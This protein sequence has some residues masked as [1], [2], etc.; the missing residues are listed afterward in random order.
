MSSQPIPKNYGMNSS[1]I[2]P[3]NDD[4]ATPERP[5]SVHSNTSSKKHKSFKDSR[6]LNKKMEIE[7]PED[8]F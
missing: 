4:K 8:E 2:N 7:I 5:G 1:E 3:E 6:T